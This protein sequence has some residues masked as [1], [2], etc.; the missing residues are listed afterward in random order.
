MNIKEFSLLTKVFQ[1]SG[2][3]LLQSIN[4]SYDRHQYTALTKAHLKLTK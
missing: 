3:R 1:T 2:K 4:G